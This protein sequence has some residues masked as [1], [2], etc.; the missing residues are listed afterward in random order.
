[1]QQPDAPAAEV[2]LDIGGWISGPART[3][4]RREIARDLRDGREGVV[5]ATPDELGT[6]RLYWLRPF[7]G[8][9]EWDVPKQFV[10]ILGELPEGQ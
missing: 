5:M 7:G 4:K 8:G 10:L 1:M 3:V 9:R 2:I 6:R